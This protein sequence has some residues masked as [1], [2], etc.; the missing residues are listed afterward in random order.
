[1]EK[2][3]QTRRAFDGRLLK[4]DVLDVELDNG[5][6]AIREVVRHPGAVAA[7]VRL[8]SGR[9]LL[10]RQFRKAIEQDLLEVV[11]GGREPGEPA[12]Q[13]A[14]R[15]VLEETGGRVERLTPLG[16]VFSAPG[17]CA[18]RLDLFLADVSANLDA[19]EGDEDETLEIVE[20]AR[21]DIEKHIA[22]GDIHDAK[23][24]AA[25]ALF[26][27]QTQGHTPA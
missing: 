11:A 9:F 7:L 27:A 18:E 20:L 5:R 24:L 15:E 4:V 23:S 14:I 25:W 17:F 16:H 6:R 10:V 2:T 13:C 21:A 26:T 22:A 1:M 8:P 19:P 12:E 3:L